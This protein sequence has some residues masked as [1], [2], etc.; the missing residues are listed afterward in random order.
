MKSKHTPLL[1]MSMIILA[2]VLFSSCRTMKHKCNDCPT[3]SHTPPEAR[4]V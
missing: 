4:N 1:L 2:M 3:F